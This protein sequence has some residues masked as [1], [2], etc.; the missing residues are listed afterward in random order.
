[1]NAESGFPEMHGAIADAENARLLTLGFDGLQ[2]LLDKLSELDDALGTLAEVGDEATRNGARRLKAQIAG[3]EPGVT[4]I[5]QVKSGKTSLVNAMIGRP[6]LLPADVNPWTSVVTSLHLDPQAPHDA[7]SAVFRF[8]ETD[9]WA[10]LLDKGGRLGELASRA[11]ADE[12][13]E[14]LQRQI[15]EMREK[16]RTRLGERFELLLGQEHDYASFDAD[17]IER[18]VCLGDFFDDAE[19]DEDAL[20]QGR[21]ADITKS[22]DL[23]LRRAEYPMKL[24]IRDTPGVNDTFMMREQITIRAIRDSR[25]CVVVLSAHQALSSVDMALIRLI[26][27]IKSREVIVFV[28]RIDELSDPGKQIPEIDASIRETLRLHQGPTDAQILFGSAYWAQHALAGTLEE[29]APESTAA[30]LNWAEACLDSGV[31]EGSPLELVWK[32]SGISALFN[33]LSDRIG[34]GVGQELVDRVAR[35]TANLAKGVQTASGALATR[36]GG[37]PKLILPRAELLAEIDRIGGLGRDMLDSQFEKVIGDYRGRIDRSHTSFLER[38][39]A[40]LISHLETKGDKVVWSYDPTGLRMLLRSGHQLFSARAQK[41]AKLVYE[42][43]AVELG[44]LYQRAFDLSEEVQIAAPPPPSIAPPVEIGQTIALDIRGNWWRS[45]WQRRR[46]YQAYAASF[47]QMIM[48][49]TEPLIRDLK[50]AQAEAVHADAVAALQG[51]MDE[52]REILVGLA[53]RSGAGPA[54]NGAEARLAAITDVM[55]S[56]AR[57]AA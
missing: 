32:L 55:A 22:A 5:G 25:L 42:G 37:A 6:D 47:Y 1:M 49:E 34:A 39:T 40:A 43:M 33:A 41:A 29:M 57:D 9:E 20:Q 38:A 30:L 19:E 14:K 4:M 54:D 28:N 13:L 35:S 44:Q 7:G 11:G 17:L 27:N 12:E 52:Q 16:S 24:C 50:Q 48:A 21:F 8:F 45:W 2:G 3:F 10:K 26:S 51:F 56:L 23:Q 46:G 36:D 53:D 18:Y 31:P 15:E